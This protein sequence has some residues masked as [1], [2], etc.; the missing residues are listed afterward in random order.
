MVVGIPKDQLPGQEALPLQ[1]DQ[2]GQAGQA[3]SKEA[4][5]AGLPAAVIVVI[6]VD[7][8]VDF[9]AV[10]EEASAVV[11]EG[12]SDTNPEAASAEEV[13]MAEGMVTAQHHP[14]MLLQ[15]QAEE[16]EAV[17]AVHRSVVLL[18]MAL[19]ARTA[20]LVGMALHVVVAHMTTDPLIVA[21]AAVVEVGSA[22]AALEASRAVIA[23]PSDLVKGVTGTG[24]DTAAEDETTTMGAGRGIMMAMAMMIHAANGDISRFCGVTSVCWV[25]FV[26]DFQHF[27]PSS[28]W[29][30]KTTF[31]FDTFRL[32]QASQW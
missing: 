27:F 17:S 9:A 12:A 11:E 23:S 24:I 20:M 10:I 7:S 13:G 5:V 18:S 4:S 16:A 19:R 26:S 25:G 1:L 28:T 30:R 6:A 29:V 3:A 2:A 8:E 22:M 21:E 15:V 32:H 31:I 14:L